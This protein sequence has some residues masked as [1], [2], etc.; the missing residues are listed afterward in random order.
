MKYARGRVCFCFSIRKPASVCDSTPTSR[1]SPTA[2]D[3]AATP[4]TS[5]PYDS[6]KSRSTASAVVFPLPASPLN[7]HH[8]VFRLDCGEDYPFLPVIEVAAEFLAEPILS[9]ITTDRAHL[10]A[11]LRHPAEDV[12]LLL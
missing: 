6:A 5:Y 2:D 9:D 4:R 7:A 11:A 10:P 8:A 3:V 12:P 1:N